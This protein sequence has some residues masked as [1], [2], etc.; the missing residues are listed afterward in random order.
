MKRL[1]YLAMAALVAFAACDEGETVVTPPAPV[2]GSIT[3]TVT[4]DGGGAAGVTVTLNNGTSASTDASGR[5]TF[6]DVL[7]GA[8]TITISGFAADATF[9]STSAA[10]VMQTSG[11]VVTADFSGSYIKTASIFG[12]VTVG[13]AAIAG[14]NVSVAGISSC[15]TTTDANGQF[16][17]GG[18]R[19]G[20][21]TVTISGF[22]SSQYNFGTTA[23]TFAL[24]AGETKVVSFTG[25]LRATASISGL[26]FID[27]NDQNKNYDGAALEPS[28][29]AANIA[30][31]L[32]GPNI[33]NTVTVQTAADGS[34]SFTNLAPGSYVV[35]IASTDPQVPAGLTFAGDTTAVAVVITTAGTASTVNFPF[36]ITTQRVTVSA[37]FG[38]DENAS[39][40][41]AAFK[42]GSRV[43]P[44]P[45]TVINLYPTEATARAVINGG[46][47]TVGRIGTGT[48]NSSGM[49]T[50]SFLR[51][52]D[53]S[54]QG[55]TDRIVFAVA[56]T[57]PSVDYELNGENPLEINYSATAL[58]FV[59]PDVFDVLNT[60]ITFAMDAKTVVTGAGLKGWNASVWLND[61]TSVATQTK[62]TST[63]TA[64][65]GK[66]AFTSVD[67][68]GTLPTT[69]WM[70]L[71]RT[72]AVQP[73]NGHAFVQEAAARAG[74]N[75]NE[76][77]K[78]VHNGVR[79]TTDTVDVGSE[80]VT[81]L[82]ATVHL[83]VHHE[84]DDVAN[85]TAGDNYENADNID[86]EL[87]EGAVKR[88]DPAN[89]LTTT[90]KVQPLLNVATMKN[91]TARARS[92]IPNT[93]VVLN[94]TSVAFTMDG[95]D[96]TM[97]LAP[98][99]GAKGNSTFA[100]KYN[101]GT[102][103]GTV[104][105][106]DG[107]GVGAAGVI[108]TLTP[109][110]NN[111]QPGITSVTKTVAA[112]GS[113]AFTGLREGPYT[114]TVADLSNAN[115]VLWNH[116]KN[117]F[118]TA[119]I[120]S[121]PREL[122]GNSNTKTA[123]FSPR[124][125]QTTVAGA[126]AN[127]RDLDGNVL[128]PNEALAGAVMSIF[129][130]LDNDGVI[131]TNE[132]TAIAT[133]TTTATGGYSFGTIPAGRYLIQAPAGAVGGTAKVLASINAATGAANRLQAVTTTAAAKTAGT[134]SPNPLPSWN[135][136][137][138]TTNNAG[139][140]NFT[141]LFSNATLTGTAA[142]AGGTKVAGM[143]LTIVRCLTSNAVTS[144]PSGTGACT[145]V[146]PGS[147]QNITT[148][149]T[150]TFTLSGLEEGVYRVTPSPITA[151][152]TG[153]TPTSL[154]FKLV[155]TGDIET[156]AFVIN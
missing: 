36:R 28:V 10:V 69:Y 91:Y 155:D 27:E 65:A 139:A 57:L 143:T 70:R 64:T 151:G 11:Q 133:A 109:G 9:G 50:F 88:F 2:T 80:I 45:G 75:T 82:D 54:P 135:Y 16:N 138:S 42:P 149:A 87:W 62:Q 39:G 77:L 19:A 106:E 115:G 142:T 41:A 123:S 6:S 55:G 90:G 43:A 37:M 76:W 89:P 126:V 68:V 130:D 86:V 108:V 107:S 31:T 7:A 24:G 72:A 92:S 101:N 140:T 125:M 48:T 14:V 136:D 49:V 8:Y 128:D 120:T 52:A 58:T 94:D 95:S 113:Y 145:L 46:A 17:C 53:T 93:N 47:A 148:S 63:A 98:L 4:V 131:D 156:G 40:L 38:K 104:V 114:V 147:T 100:Y 30:I 146:V 3:G 102:I 34:Y 150:G 33:G 153:S 23:Q 51:T 144:P 119:E 99:K 111:I 152:Y 105:A 21:Y 134:V 117:T 12:S 97:T 18:M 122:Q 25:S 85:N 20:S 124:Y 132:A 29:G 121:A 44:V 137:T 60:R 32:E 35:K 13:T 67:A 66:V 103:S 78:V 83:S 79:L 112:N 1:K 127:D 26:L 84:M 74:T 59:A 15:S 73:S 129:E 141:F 5:Y 71:D 61:T 96:T 118:V 22:N 56:S 116:R 81:Y 110:A 154:L